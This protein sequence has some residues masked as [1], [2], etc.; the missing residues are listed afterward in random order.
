[1]KRA[2]KLWT[3]VMAMAVAVPVMAADAERGHMLHE[4]SCLSGCHASRVQGHPNDIYTR[5]GRKDT[6]EKVQAQVAFCNQQVLNTLW[7]PEDEAN[8]VAYLNNTFYKF[9]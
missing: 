8:V 3:L 6:L 7:W 2:V 1:M 4:Q 5:K 9:K